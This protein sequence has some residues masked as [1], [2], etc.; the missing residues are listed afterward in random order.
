[1]KTNLNLIACAIAG[2]FFVGCASTDSTQISTANTTNTAKRAIA[3]IDQVPIT[4]SRIAVKTSDRYV[5]TT[6]QDKADNPVRSLG[7]DI[8]RPSN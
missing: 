7:N 1:M 5:K 2:L 3:N 6:V 8:G 4:G